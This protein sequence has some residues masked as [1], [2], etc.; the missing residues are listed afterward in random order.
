M[1]RPNL[2]H[3]QAL[4]REFCI[5]HDISYTQRNLFRSY[6]DVFRYLHKVGEPLRDVQR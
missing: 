6:G 2:R 3:A 4:V 1:P 5:Q